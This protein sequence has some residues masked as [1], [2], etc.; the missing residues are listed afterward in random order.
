[1]GATSETEI[2][3]IALTRIGHGTISSLDENTTAAQ[4]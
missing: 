3:N 2:C 1:M 4:V